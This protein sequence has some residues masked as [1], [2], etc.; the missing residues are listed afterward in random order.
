MR[1]RGFTGARAARRHFV[2]GDQFTLDY[3]G[4]YIIAADGWPLWKI[5]M[6]NDVESRILGI[7][8]EAPFPV[9]LIAA[10]R[11]PDER[12]P[13]GWWNVRRRDVE[14]KLHEAMAPFHVNGEWF[15][16]PVGQRADA[17]RRI[18]CVIKGIESDLGPARDLIEGVRVRDKQ[19]GAPA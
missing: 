13:R 3:Q 1:G 8:A 10:F 6:A 15:E 12:D 16:V 11:V 19:T 5:G 9:R 18:V 14:R 2:F 4:V 17:W 7:A